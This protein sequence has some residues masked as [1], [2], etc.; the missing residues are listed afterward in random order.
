MADESAKLK[1]WTIKSHK[2]RAN[3]TLTGRVHE[4]GDVLPTLDFLRAVEEGLQ[5]NG[6]NTEMEFNYTSTVSW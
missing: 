3:V 6:W 1:G 5:S 2:D 4:E